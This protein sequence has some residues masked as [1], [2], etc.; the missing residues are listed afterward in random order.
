[1]NND[2]EDIQGIMVHGFKSID[3][4]PNLLNR[5]WKHFII[6]QLQRK[7]YGRIWYR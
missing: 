5:K 7:H 6:K 1:M 3:V 2:K 4:F